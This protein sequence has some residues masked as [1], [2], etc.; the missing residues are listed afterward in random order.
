MLLTT[1]R[2]SSL[3]ASFSLQTNRHRRQHE[4]ATDSWL[5]ML[6]S[7]M[8]FAISASADNVRNVA[9]WLTRTYKGRGDMFWVALHHEGGGGLRRRWA[10]MAVRVFAGTL[11]IATSVCNARR[12]LIH[13]TRWILEQHRQYGRAVSCS[14]RTCG[15]QTLPCRNKQ[16]SS[17]GHNP[18]SSTCAQQN[19][20]FIFQ[21]LHVVVFPPQASRV[22]YN[23]IMLFVVL[24]MS[25]HALRA[26]YAPTDTVE[27][28]S[29]C[30]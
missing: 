4:A 2:T 3:P 26:G 5:V 14:W 8:I 19:Q 29:S 20:Q 22:W 17:Y 21:S 16:P 11:S 12:I 13:C 9:T 7:P 25:I 24:H 15:P 30:V 27:R 10:G 6:A 28:S 18:C 1:L 23:M